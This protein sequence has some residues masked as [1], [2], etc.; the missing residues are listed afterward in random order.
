VRQNVSHHQ[1]GEKSCKPHRIN[2]GPNPLVNALMPSVFHTVRTQCRVERYFCPS[3]G[4]KPSVCIRDLTISIGYI[5]AQS[6]R[7]SAIR[8]VHII[9]TKNHSQR[10]LPPR[11]KESRYPGL[12]ALGG[13]LFAPSHAALASHMPKSIRRTPLPLGGK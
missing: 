5:T 1:N 13:C 6:Y 9:C 12:S 10:S 3:D 7:S 11:H 2:V 8:R 4:E